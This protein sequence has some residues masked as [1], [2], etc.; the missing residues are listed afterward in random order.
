MSAK[1][2]LLIVSTLAQLA[3]V[4]FAFRVMR[5][6]KIKG[7]W[8]ILV[9]AFLLMFFRRL[10]SVLELTIGGAAFS[11]IT[12]EAI[13]LTISL[14][15][16]I[17]MAFVE[18]LFTRI[19]Q[20][21]ETLRKNEEQLRSFIQCS[22]FAVAMFD[23]DMRYIIASNRWL[24]DFS[25]E[26]IV[27][28]SHYEISPEIP[29]RWKLIH[30]STLA[31]KVEKCDE[32]PFLRVDGN[33]QWIK[34]ETRPWINSMGEIGGIIIFSEDI[35]E[36]RQADM[37]L[38]ESKQQLQFVTD[39]APVI[40]AHCDTNH[41]YKFVNRRYAERF[42]IKREDIIGK[43]IPEVVGEEAYSSFKQYVDAVL[44]G[45]YIEFETEIPYQSIGKHYMRVAYSPEFNENGEISGFVAV[46]IDISDR[47]RAEEA[48]RKAHNELEIR[49]EERT[50][51]L[52]RANE[53]LAEIS[54]RLNLALE[55]A[56]IGTWS[57]SSKDNMLIWDDFTHELFGR[58]IGT[59]PNTY[60][61]F[62][63]YLHPDDRDR[64]NSTVRQSINEG[65]SYETDYR[66]IWPDGSVH[67]IAA[68]GRVYHNENSE[69]IRMAGVCWDI[70]DKEK[71]VA[72]LI[73]SEST[74]RSFYDSAAMMMG[75]V[76]IADNNIIHIS[77]N[78]TSLNFFGLSDHLKDINA[79]DLGI[80]EEIIQKWIGHYQESK[81]SGKPVR[82]EYE[83]RISS[84]T[85]WLAATVSFIGI[86]SNNR[87]RFSYIIDDVSEQ[88]LMEETIRENERRLF[89]FIEAVPEGIFVIDAQGKAYYSNKAAQEIQG[90]GIVAN[91]A[92]GELAEVY[93][94]YI[95]GTNQKYPTDR[96][97]IVRALSGEICA[98]DDME[99]QRPDRR[100]P[101]Q[102]KAVPIY[103][104]TGQIIYAIATFSD[105]SER[106]NTEKILQESKQF[107]QSTLNA[108]SAHVSIIDE[109]GNIIA[110]NES[111]RR[112]ADQNGLKD[113]NYG[114]GSNYLEVC[115]SAL[116]EDA[117]Q[118]TLIGS[119][120]REL[121]DKEIDIFTYEYSCHSPTEK[122]W[123]LM[124]ATRFEGRDGT[125]VVISHENITDLKKAEEELQNQKELLSS[126]LEHMGDAVIVADGYHN[127][128]LSNPAAANILG[129]GENHIDQTICTKLLFLPDAITPYPEKELP[130]ARSIRGE[131]VNNAEVYVRY[132]N[133]AGGIWI[134]VT[135]RPL[136]DGSGNLMGGVIVFR[137]IT[138]RKQAEEVLAKQAKELARSNRELEQFAYIASH[139]LQ[140][141][142]RMVASFTQLLAKQYK[143]RLDD[144]ADSYIS[145]AVDGALRMQRLIKDLLSY[146]RVTGTEKNLTSIDCN[147]ILANVLLSLTGAI[148]ENQATITHDALPTIMADPLQLGQLFQ[149]LI[150]NAIKY[151]GTNP[152][153]IHISVKKQEKEWVFSV[154]DNGIGIDPEFSEKIF[155]LFQRLHNKQDYPGTGIGLAICKKIVESHGG[156]I[157]MESQVG[158]GATFF[159]SLPLIPT[160]IHI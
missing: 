82:F 68:R 53:E 79:R 49:V 98:I 77:D 105:I 134:T 159:F 52:K 126:I 46:I 66:V 13:A 108:L 95:A 84:N 21:E 142:L 74:L 29:E 2:L 3:V 129:K 114:V 112:F 88:K 99:I 146:S 148:E 106:R 101:I 119:G 51:E 15:L 125:Q 36:H 93:D 137:D 87:P 136:K 45:E 116:N 104:G 28:R 1:L 122:R 38:Q 128:L 42:G 160:Q 144:D 100:V 31:G 92:I 34:W 8:L 109:Q 103:N 25:L 151:R 63:S 58:A 157:W 14:L 127:I 147:S 23:K 152:P 61:A 120:L 86:S 54:E 97:P 65:T 48:L 115:Q 70:T 24:E 18:K 55:S 96:M 149:N 139:D 44:R 78:Q 89:Q 118:T 26:D 9:S 64:V 16:L 135:G 19:K 33:V 145:F 90:K 91:T 133:G 50:V 32:D 143:G 40:I 111:W 73:E 43:R 117:E 110:V 102:V 94:T 153:K 30:Q 130:L 10:I 11:P 71:A 57:W 83:H 12:S 141:P 156:R 80:S 59:Y 7:A 155:I 107:L 121:I 20:A 131:I 69:A 113:N 150:G 67:A 4:F 123:F 75:I 17:G 124:R 76:E 154:K 140:E 37:V 39:N 5:A 132:E 56:K 35:T 81:V 62:L 60:E 72:S 27:G 85:Y 41:R 47:K 22:P 138:E 6:T 158:E